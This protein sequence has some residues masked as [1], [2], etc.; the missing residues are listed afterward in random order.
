MTVR[1][2]QQTGR[3]SDAVE[4]QMDVL[5]GYV[6]L[7]GVIVSVVLVVAGLVWHWAS[8]GHVGVDYAIAPANLFDFVV[9]DVRQ[10]ASPHV[11]P[12]LLVS[13]G[14]AALM[15]TPY[16]RVL[17]ALLFFAIAEHNW[18]YVAFTA[19]VLSVLTFSLFLR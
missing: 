14:I 13:L 12:R 10:I 8:T 7:G 5:I 18:K 15:L 2:T 4:A 11:R 19:F 3:R 1:E 16:V 6:L 9:T 17:V